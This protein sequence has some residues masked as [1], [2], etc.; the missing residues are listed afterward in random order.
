MWFVAEVQETVLV[1]ATYRFEA[2]DE[3]E[4]RRLMAADGLGTHYRSQ[5]SEPEGILSRNLDTLTIL[6]RD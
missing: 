5:N 2:K 6:P 4:A 1:Y 3:E